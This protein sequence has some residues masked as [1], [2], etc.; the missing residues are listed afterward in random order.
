MGIWGMYL[1]QKVGGNEL[2]R[3]TWEEAS[4]KFCEYCVWMPDI[5]EEVGEDFDVLFADFLATTAVMDYR[6]RGVL[7]DVRRTTTVR[8]MP[9]EG[10]A[11]SYG[12]PQ[13]LGM[14][15]IEF[16]ANLGRTG[17]V[18]EVTFDGASYPDYWIVVL[19][20]G[21]TEV[22]EMVVFELDDVGDGSAYIDFEGD[23][24][25]H[26]IVSPVDED[27]QG[28]WYDWSDGVDFNY[29]WSAR[30]V[31]ESDVGT[32]TVVDSDDPQSVPFGEFSMSD[33]PQGCSCASGPHSS[34]PWWYSVGF[35]LLLL[36]RRRNR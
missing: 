23:Q 3:A 22:E 15:I 18:L 27:A 29:L 2:V 9:A 13:S 26:L 34:N 7:N 6:D 30:V 25:V 28:Y 36:F 19:A 21:S 16:P 31:S 20:R 10:Q 5:I 33:T 32:T 12:R 8:S 35:G 14:N 24:P 11:P 4:D 17:K 1:D